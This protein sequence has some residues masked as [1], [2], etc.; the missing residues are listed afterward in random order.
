MRT[1]T[2]YQARQAD[3]AIIS[4]SCTAVSPSVAVVMCR[5]Q[6]LLD[7]LISACLTHAAESMLLNRSIVVRT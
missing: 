5:S 2:Q 3:L 4:D 1:A 7:V 6:T